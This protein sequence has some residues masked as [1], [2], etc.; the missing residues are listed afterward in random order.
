MKRLVIT[1][2]AGLPAFGGGRTAGPAMHIAYVINALE[3]G[4]DTELALMA[5]RLARRGTAKVEIFALELVDERAIH[6]FQA[7]G[8]AAHAGVGGD[9]LGSLYWLTVALAA[10]R[11][12]VIWTSQTRATVLGQEVGRDLDV[13]VVSWLHAANLQAANRLLLSARRA[14]SQLWIADS[15]SAER[16]ASQQ[17]AIPSESLA[18]W[19]VLGALA[20]GAETSDRGG[21]AVVAR[22]FDLVAP[23][24]RPPS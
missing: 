22:L 17:L 9:P 5:A 16:V 24:R 18:V 8:F 7:A 13:P 10:A 23:S 14:F 20:T 11:P 15:A 3:V 1:P 4:P 12:D 19:P 6:A 21:A 2:G